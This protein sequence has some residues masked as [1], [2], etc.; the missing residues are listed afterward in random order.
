MKVIKTT[1]LILLVSFTFMNFMFYKADKALVLPTEFPYIK[2][3]INTTLAPLNSG[4][5]VLAVKRA[6]ENW[7]RMSKAKILFYLDGSSSR[8]SPY[9]PS[10]YECSDAAQEELFK[11]E[12]TVYAVSGNDPDCTGPACTF[13]W[14]CGDK[15]LH[16]DVQINSQDYAWGVLS[17][18]AEESESIPVW[19]LSLIPTNSS[20]SAAVSN[21]YDLESVL[22]HAFGH[23]AGLDH[24]IPGD[25]EAECLAKT[26]SGHSN[27]L[28][29]EVMHKFVNPGVVKTNLSNDDIAG[30]RTLYGELKTTLPVTGDYALDKDE[31]LAIGIEMRMQI[32]DGHDTVDARQAQARSIQEMY[33][34]VNSGDIDEALKW[35]KIPGYSSGMKFEEYM[36]SSYRIIQDNLYS[37]TDEEL[38]II[39]QSSSVGIVEM[40]DMINKHTPANGVASKNLLEQINQKNME[41]R[42]AVIDEQ[43][44]RQ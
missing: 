4:M 13:V 20:T 24:C 15:I 3:K 26:G 33:N 31:I 39:R 32:R 27:P 2:F 18:P 40:D 10:N 41:L 1:L 7:F 19:S 23:A 25:T 28:I 5:S 37:R 29:S 9:S 8:R 44:R 21:V 11:Q 34:F 35:E 22:T 17:P 38:K 36:D 43:R 42:K 6:A 16:F 12:K 30:I 14:S